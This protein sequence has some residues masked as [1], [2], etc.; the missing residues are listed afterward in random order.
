[1][2]RNR[3]QFLRARNERMT[4]RILSLRDDSPYAFE[5]RGQLVIVYYKGAKIAK[6]GPPIEKLDARNYLQIPIEIQ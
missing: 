5:E 1:M 4:A 3:R 6:I 2:E